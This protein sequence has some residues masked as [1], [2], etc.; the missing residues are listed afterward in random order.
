MMS[1]KQISLVCLAMLGLTAC[2]QEKHLTSQQILS[3][4]VYNLEAS[5]AVVAEATLPFIQGQV[6]GVTL[7]EQDKQLIHKANITV[8]NEITTLKDA[9]TAGK[10]LS[11]T[12]VDAAQTD[13]SSFVNCW[14]SIKT[15]PTQ[16][17]TPQSCTLLISKGQ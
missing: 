15:N 9:V 4:S 14:V 2:A 11:V 7:T 13:L 1:L 17:T 12:L 6:P 16:T 3:Q 10:P 5:Y 8:F